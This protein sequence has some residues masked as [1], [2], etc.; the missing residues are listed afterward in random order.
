MPIAEE[1]K[2]TAYYSNYSESFGANL[3][4]VWPNQAV[5][6][7]EAEQWEVGAKTEFFGGRLRATLAYYDLTKTNVA[8]DDNLRPNQGFSVVAGAV[9]SRGPELDIQG[10]ILPGWNVIAT[11]ANTDVVTTKTFNA[12]PAQGDRYH[13]VPRNT[14]S[15]WNT[16]E[17]KNGD[18]QGLKVGGGI[19]LRDNQA[20]NDPSGA[21]LEVPGYETVD[22]MAAYSRNIGKSKISGQF[23]VN[24]L[25]DKYHYSSIMPYRIPSALGY[26]TS[27]VSFGTPRSFM[28]SIKI[29]Y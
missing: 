4:K 23:N 10:K 2:S 27:Y 12:Y 20:T 19:T 25:L 13:G 9:L 17:F 16:Y 21:D 29:E 11:Y 5:P 7:S 3:G 22:L 28:G 1:I 24:N 15:F 8:T 6:P 18:W 14:A 26:D